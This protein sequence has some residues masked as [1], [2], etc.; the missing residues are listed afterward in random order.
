M[1]EEEPLAGG[2][3]LASHAAGILVVTTKT[4]V[5]E[6]PLSLTLSVH[7]AGENDVAGVSDALI[8]SV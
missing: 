5:S 8:V 4:S 1:G 2:V 7:M 6:A 3:R